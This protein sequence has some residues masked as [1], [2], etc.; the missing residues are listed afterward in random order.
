MNLAFSGVL[1]FSVAALFAVT[2]SWKPLTA[3]V[4]GCK[5]YKILQVQN[6]GQT[7]VVY[8]KAI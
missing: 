3:K 4:N 6:N 2:F 7:R 5:T 1:F 8:E